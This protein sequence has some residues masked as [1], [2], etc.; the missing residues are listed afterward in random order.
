MLKSKVDSPLSFPIPHFTE[1][2]LFV[3]ATFFR[4]IAAFL[5]LYFLPAILMADVNLVKNADFSIF[6]DGLPAEWVLLAEEQKISVVNAPSSL[7]YDTAL[8]VEVITPNERQ[9]GAIRQHIQVKPNT[10]YRLSGVLRGTRSELAFLQVK[11][12]RANKE[13]KRMNSPR[14]S[15]GWTRE[16]IVFNTGNADNLLVLCRWEQH[17]KDVGNSLWFSGI[18]LIEKIEAPL[19][20]TV[21]YVLE[22]LALPTFESIGLYWKPDQGAADNTCQLSYRRKGDKSWKQ[23]HDLWFDPN[24]H[25]DNVHGREYRGSLVHLNPGTEYEIRLH[26]EKTGTEGIVVARTWSDGFPV[27]K[28][29]HLPETWSETLVIW[30]G[31]S[32][33]DGYVVYAPAPGKTSIGNAKGAQEVNVRIEAPYVILRNLTLRGAEK[34]GI[35]IAGEHHIVIEHCD[36]SGWGR[37]AED[38]FGVNGDS[39]IY[40]N[41]DQLEHIVIQNCD[42]HHPRTHSNSWLESRTRSDGKQTFHPMGP[43]GITFLKG[44]GRYVFRH[45]T[46]RS[47]REHMFND[48]MGEFANFSFAGFPN[49]DSDIYGNLVSHCRDDGFEIEGANMNVRVWN[50]MTDMTMM[51]LAAA[52]TSL[53]PVYF[54]R[55]IALRSRRGPKTHE[56]GD[57]G[58]ALLKLGNESREYTKGRIYVYH[59]TVLQEPNAS[60]M[61]K[62]NGVSDGIVLTGKRKRQENIITRNNILQCRTHRNWAIRDPLKSPTNDFDYDLYYGK[63]EARQGSETHGIF[64]RPDFRQNR[65]ERPALHPGTPGHDA[66]CRIPNFNDGFVGLAPDMGAIEEGLPARLPWSKLRHSS[67]PIN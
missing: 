12:R 10:V 28:V 9:Q 49:R 36:I 32:E 63:L 38:G 8:G 50:N 24:I 41:S 44:K 7:P 58:G 15:T 57:R 3:N 6:S 25:A 42:L 11:L 2:V 52:S 34:H 13:V 65:K 22:P 17:P 5:V 45:N 64:G 33:Q 61:A 54:W 60:V 59:N 43:Q 39:A 53:G 29:I 35:E 23:G 46:I 27:K 21:N 4:S 51:S 18:E 30:E 67:Q 47:D 1:N 19:P 37:V 56:A 31:G 16:E 48:G 26:L 55:N 66:G 20:T 14:N 62:A 40:G